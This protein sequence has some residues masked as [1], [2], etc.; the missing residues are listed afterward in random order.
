[1]SDFTVSH[2]CTRCARSYSVELRRMRWKLP[3][4]C[5]GCGFLT[6]VSQTQAIEAHRLLERLELEGRES[7]VA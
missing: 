1:M 7:K 6:N 4:A 5:P 2:T 3:V